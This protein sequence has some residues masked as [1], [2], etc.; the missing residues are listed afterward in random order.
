ML[1]VVSVLRSG[2]EYSPDWVGKLA[3][4]VKRHLQVPHRFACLSDVEVPCERIEMQENWPGWW[5]KIELFRPGV[6]EGP[7]LYI[8]L[9]NVIVGDITILS[10]LPYEFAMTRNLNH[11]G[12]ASSTVMWWKE[13]ADSRIYDTFKEQSADIMR[14]YAFHGDT[15]MG[16]QGFIWDMMD[17]KVP[18]LSDFAPGL[19]RSYRNHCTMGIPKGCSIIAFGGPLKPNNQRADWIAEAWN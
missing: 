6:I 5:S 17:R 7:T 11:P 15:H 1:T 13:R 19:I 4:S 2:G 12:N 3:R 16:D 9:D 18:F 8:D 10:N 14:E